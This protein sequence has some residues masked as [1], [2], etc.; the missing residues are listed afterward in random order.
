MGQTLLASWDAYLPEGVLQEANQAEHQENLQDIRLA[1]VCAL[2]DHKNLIEIKQT[3]ANKEGLLCQLVSETDFI[4]YSNQ[5]KPSFIHQFTTEQT[6]STN[7]TAVGGNAT[8]LE[9]GS[10]TD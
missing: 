4:N 9:L 2:T 3:L 8:L 7:T 6:I 1:G 10:K 5:A